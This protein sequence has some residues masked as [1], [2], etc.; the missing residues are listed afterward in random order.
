MKR[1]LIPILGLTLAAC[2]SGAPTFTYDAS[3]T[4]RV[5][6]RPASGTA[7]QE[8]GTV[9]LTQEEGAR[10]TGTLDSADGPTHV[11]VEGNA[12]TGMLT[13]TGSGTVLKITGTFSGNTYTGTY[14]ASTDAS[15]TVDSGAWR[16]TR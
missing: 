14:A 4:W 9:Q 12:M 15:D 8:A 7:F 10:L 11:P 1:L 13:V 5:E 2:S 3:G 16:M 6:R